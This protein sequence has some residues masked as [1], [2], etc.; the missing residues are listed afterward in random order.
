MYSVLRLSYYSNKCIYENAG[1]QLLL[2]QRVGVNFFFQICIN[3]FGKLI[4][5]HLQVGLGI[6]WAVAPGRPRTW[7]G[8]A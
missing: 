2:G 3:E 5:E 8:M 6:R 1:P 4:A 7:D